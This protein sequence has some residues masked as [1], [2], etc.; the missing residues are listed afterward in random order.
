M[1]GNGP[2]RLFN[3]TD[4]GSS[5]CKDSIIN[6][7]CEIYVLTPLKHTQAHANEHHYVI[8]PAAC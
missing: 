8:K 5:Q 1:H 4:A 7:F 3:F 6:Q 2:I